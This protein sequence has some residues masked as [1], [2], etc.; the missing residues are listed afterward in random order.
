MIGRFEI[1]SAKIAGSRNEKIAAPTEPIFCGLCVKGWINLVEHAAAGPL[2]GHSSGFVFRYL[3]WK[4]G[5][6]LSL[7]VLF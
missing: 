4:C 5:R 1:F 7:R 2:R 6:R 3:I